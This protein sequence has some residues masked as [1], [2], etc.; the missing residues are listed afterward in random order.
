ML[1]ELLHQEVLL[2]RHL[3]GSVLSCVQASLVT[4]TDLVILVRLK[5]MLSLNHVLVGAEGQKGS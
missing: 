2:T 1:L 5:K 4:H 3:H